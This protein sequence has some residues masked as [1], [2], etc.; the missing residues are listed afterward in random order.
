MWKQ[1]RT[2]ITNNDPEKIIKLISDML[3]DPQGN[4]YG[5]AVARDIMEMIATDHMPQTT[6]ALTLEMFGLKP[7]GASSKTF[8]QFLKE[9]PDIQKNFDNIHNGIDDIFK[10]QDLALIGRIIDETYDRN[11]LLF[12]TKKLATDFSDFDHRTLKLIIKKAAEQKDFEFLADLSQ[13]VFANEKSAKWKDLISDILGHAEE[14][15]NW[16]ILG[17]FSEYVFS[18][19]HAKDWEDLIWKTMNIAL[20][21]NEPETFEDLENYVFNKSFAK[22]KKWDLLR[23]ALRAPSKKKYLES[24]KEAIL[25]RETP[26]PLKSKKRPPKPSNA[27]TENILVNNKQISKD[28]PNGSTINLADGK[29]YLVEGKIDQGKRGVV[30]K[31]RNSVDQKVYV[32]KVAVDDTPETV[33]SFNGEAGKINALKKYKVKTADIIVT[34][35]NYFLKE[36]IDGVRADAYIKN[37]IKNGA[38]KND[39]G[40]VRL[41]AWINELAQK[42]IY[43]GDL[44][45]KNAIYSNGQWV[46][47]DSGS[48]KEGVSES[49]ALSRYIDNISLRWAKDLKKPNEGTQNIRDAISVPVIKDMGVDGLFQRLCPK[50]H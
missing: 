44:N 23:E 30:Y 38:P 8:A 11:F 37:W 29:A 27:T 5:V 4:K 12:L 45:R 25:Q 26:T 21:I 15:K 36:F 47:I 50:L 13:N 43:V 48:V 2:H 6:P 34:G 46:I 49:E 41:R 40:I 9:N 33:K 17:D 31:V 7:I 42:N 32:L 28:L 24:I 3:S 19:P 1:I 22:G 35:E 18:K 20:E 10:K 16:D 14:L 39:V